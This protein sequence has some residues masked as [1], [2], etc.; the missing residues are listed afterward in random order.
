M[1]PIVPILASCC[2]QGA[3]PANEAMGGNMS[4]AVTR[5]AARPF[6]AEQK[7]ALI[8][9]HYA[10]PAEAAAVPELVDQ[11]HRDMARTRAELIAGAEQDRSLRQEKDF[12]FHGH[13][14]STDYSAAGQSAGLLSLMIEQGSYTGGA[15]GNF[16]VGAL[17]WDRRD[18]RELKVAELFAAADNMTRLLTQR[19]CDALNGAREAK[20]GEPVGGSGL[21]EDCPKLDEIAIIPADRNGN[22]RFERLLLVAS[23]YVAGPWVEGSYEIEVAITPELLTAL[24]D[25]YRPDFEAAQTQ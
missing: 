24:K 9:F 10:W 5:P 19:W 25:Q 4:A 12:D 11:F 7:D 20:R 8:E 14:S 13:M 16:G 2:S 22:A 15:H 23:P 6:V 18:K 21:F 17:L 3:L 1:L